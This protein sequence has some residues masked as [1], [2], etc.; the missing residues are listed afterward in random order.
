MSTWTY[1][2]SIITG[3]LAL[4]ACT[5][6]AQVGLGAGGLA[7]SRAAP[8]RVEVTGDAVVITGPPGY[9]IDETST[10]DNGATAFVLLGSCASIARDASVDAPDAPAIL[11]VTVS[12][13]VF[14]DGDLPVETLGAFFE[15]EAGLNALSRTGDGTSVDVLD[16]V[17][18][19]DA[20]FYYVQDPGDPRQRAILDQ[21]WRAI[22][23]LDGRLMS[24]SAVGIE[25]RPLTRDAGLSTLETFTSILRIENASGSEDV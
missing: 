19:E 9:C 13:V 5:D 6:G 14:A 1:R 16:V 7:F 2:A 23:E 24:A 3:L 4:S 17:E 10:R 12:E 15:T 11:T 20:L 8:E 25:A 21:Y 18:T 22:F